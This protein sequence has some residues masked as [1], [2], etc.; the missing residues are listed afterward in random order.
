MWNGSAIHEQQTLESFFLWSYEIQI[1]YLFNKN[2]KNVSSEFMTENQQ[3]ERKVNHLTISYDYLIKTIW[4][5][6]QFET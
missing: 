4:D 5:L 3:E 1:I 6:S 2:H